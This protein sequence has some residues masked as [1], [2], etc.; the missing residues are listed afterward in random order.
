MRRRLETDKPLYRYLPIGRF[1]EMLE[2]NEIGFPATTQWDDPFEGFLLSKYLKEWPRREY[3]GLEDSIYCLCFSKDMEKDQIW[4]SYIHHR[5]M[6]YGS[7][8]RYVILRNVL[9]IISFSD[10]LNTRT[11]RTWEVY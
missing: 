4:R 2:T 1:I 5:K 9:I 6:A 10:P 3:N 8:W 11:N 7:K